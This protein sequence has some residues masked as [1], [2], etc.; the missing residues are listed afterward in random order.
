MRKAMFYILVFISS[1]Y[2]CS[3]IFVMDIS[4][5]NVS[6]LAPHN[7]LETTIGTQTFWWEKVE[8]AQSYNL[9]IVTPGF[10]QTER[11]ILDTT[12]SYNTFTYNL[13]PNKYEWRVKAL[14]SAYETSY[15]SFSLRIDSTNDLSN[16]TVLLTYPCKTTLTI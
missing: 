11:L 7:N 1:I 6:L 10:N 13:S 3:D 9:Q 14:N 8:D 16:E 4:E 5:D 2:G 15:T 12:I